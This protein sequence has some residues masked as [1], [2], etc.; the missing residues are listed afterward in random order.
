M[1]QMILKRLIKKEK[2]GT[3]I[4]DGGM[5]LDDFFELF[6]L[7]KEDL[8]ETE[9]VTIGGFCVEL[10]DDKFA[11]VND[12][13]NYQNLEMKVIAV[14]ENNTIEKLFIKVNKDEED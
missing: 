7:D 4:V 13:I 1:K 8:E 14:D 6:D 5:N 2:D 11:K 12:I 3:Y 10:L 9:Y